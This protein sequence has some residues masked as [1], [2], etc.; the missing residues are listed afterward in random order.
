MSLYYII[1]TIPKKEEDTLYL[2]TKLRMSLLRD[3]S[4][5][6]C[7]PL[8]F[9]D[10]QD[11]LRFAK[12]N[13]ISQVICV[14]EKTFSKKIAY[15]KHFSQDEA[16]SELVASTR[17][18][19]KESIEVCC[20]NI[21]SPAE[22]AT[23]PEMPKTH[24]VNVERKQYLRGADQDF[25][26]S[27]YIQK[28]LR[29]ADSL[30]E[31]MTA[32]EYIQRISATKL[33]DLDRQQNDELEYAEYFSLDA[34]HGYRC[35]RRLHEIRQQRRFWKDLQAA[36]SMIKPFLDQLSEKQCQNIVKAI[37]DRCIRLYELK[38]PAT[39]AHPESIFG[40]TTND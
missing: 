34:A 5:S 31:L 6:E 30:Q 36:V 13:S 29:F 9:D 35:Y 33:S 25:A 14:A 23:L 18:E 7:P 11:A 2:N 15:I 40:N 8:A 39:F 3:Y 20:E 26:D 37:A 4:S 12:D 38:S 21:C 17:K 24:P 32:S 16:F 27:E 1:R 19:D 28:F 10:P 22:K